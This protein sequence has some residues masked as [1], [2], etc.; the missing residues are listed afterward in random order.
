MPKAANSNS[1]IQD[2]TKSSHV[3]YTERYQSGTGG[4]GTDIHGNPIPTYPIYSTATHHTDAKI[5]G[6]V[7]SS[8]NVLINGSPAIKVGDTTQEQWTADPEPYPHYGGNITSVSPATSGSGSGSVTVGSSNIF[9][10]GK[11]LV[12]EGST[13]TTHLGNTTTI[14]GGSDNVIVN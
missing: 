10:N 9:V 4:G 6:T 12:F 5:T 1:T 13:V 11:A 8:S 7:S 2:S 3:T 14:D